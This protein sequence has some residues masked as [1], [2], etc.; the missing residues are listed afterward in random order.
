MLA[1]LIPL[2]PTPACNDN[3]VRLPAALAARRPAD[4]VRV[5]AAI[6]GPVT[7]TYVADRV[8]VL[9]AHGG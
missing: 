7:M 3:G 5:A 8:M 9:S 6:C 2:R 4:I 1:R